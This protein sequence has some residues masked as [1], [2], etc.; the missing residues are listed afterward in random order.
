MGCFF[1]GDSGVKSTETVTSV[2][3]VVLGF[4]C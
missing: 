4:L 3:H 2:L 1:E